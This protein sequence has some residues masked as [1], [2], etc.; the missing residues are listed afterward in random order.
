MNSSKNSPIKFTSKREQAHVQV[1]ITEQMGENADFGG[2][3][4]AGFD[5]AYATNLFTPFQRLH[6]MDEFSGTGVGLVTEQP[7]ISR[8]IGERILCPLPCMY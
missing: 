6:G 4:S 5:M 7:I 3:H 8:H 2:D 1:G